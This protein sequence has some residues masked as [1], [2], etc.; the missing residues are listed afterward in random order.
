MVFSLLIVPRFTTSLPDKAGAE[1]PKAVAQPVCAA[2]LSSVKITF[3]HALSGPSEIAFHVFSGVG[4]RQE[5]VGRAVIGQAFPGRHDR[6]LNRQRDG[7]DQ[8]QRRGAMQASTGTD[9]RTTWFR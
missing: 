5:T 2:L 1:P 3:G 7:D 6:R 9:G 8:R 4:G